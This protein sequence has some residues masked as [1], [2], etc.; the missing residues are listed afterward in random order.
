MEMDA[1][2]VRQLE[3]ATCGLRF[4]DGWAAERVIDGGRV[5][6]SAEGIGLSEHDLLVL[7]MS[8]RESA[9]TGDFLEC[10]V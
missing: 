2:P 1:C 10:L 7:L 5:T 6:A 3:Q 8:G 4:C 9:R